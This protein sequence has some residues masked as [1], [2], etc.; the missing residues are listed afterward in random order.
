MFINCIQDDAEGKLHRRTRPDDTGRRDVDVGKRHDHDKSSV[1]LQEDKRRRN[2]DNDDH[3]NRRDAKRRDDDMRDLLHEEKRSHNDDTEDDR[4]RGRTHLQDTSRQDDKRHGDDRRLALHEDKKGHNDDIEDDRGRGRTHLQDTSRHDDKRHGDDRR[5]ALNE[6]KKGHNDDKR[7][8]LYEEKRSGD[9]YQN[10]HRGY[11]AY[12]VVDD[13][14][15]A[16]HE[17]KR[18]RNGGNDDDICRGD[19]TTHIPI[20]NRGIRHFNTNSCYHAVSLGA[21]ASIPE[22][23]NAVLTLPLSPEASICNKVVFAEQRNVLQS[24]KEFFETCLSPDSNIE[25]RTNDAENVLE[26][27]EAV[28]SQMQ[29]FDG[30]SPLLSRFH[31]SDSE[32]PCEWFSHVFNCLGVSGDNL[33]NGS[34]LHNVLAHELTTEITK[35]IICERCKSSTKTVE[36]LPMS[37]LSVSR[38]V[39][40]V[41][42]QSLIDSL[43]STEKNLDNHKCRTCWKLGTEMP[44]KTIKR[45]FTRLPRTFLAMIKRQ[46]FISSNA[47]NH[48]TAANVTK[49]G[50]TMVNIGGLHYEPIVT[51]AHNQFGSDGHFIFAAKELESS[52]WHQFDDLNPNCCRV[53]TRNIVQDL[54]SKHYIIMFRLVDTS[55]LKPITPTI[56][57]HDVVHVDDCS[58]IRDHRDLDVE[59]DLTAEDTS[60]RV[61][62]VDKRHDDDKR[63]AHHEDKISRTSDNEDEDKRSRTSDNEDERDRGRVNYEGKHHE[64]TNGRDVDVGKRHD[65]EKRV[66][67]HE[68]KKSH[69]GHNEDNRD[70]R[71][72][73]QHEDTSMRVAD[74]DKRHDDDK[75]DAHHE[76]KLNRDE[77]DTRNDPDKSID[78]RD[79]KQVRS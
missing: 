50:G 69:N 38:D 72:C 11:A 18:S 49:F 1:A 3:M 21:L 44:T 45:Y 32:D 67:L 24:L 5:L 26:S 40:S 68:C 59:I 61:A 64:D 42:V 78:C 47:A 35:E 19:V 74:V 57:I 46:Q 2:G 37:L 56:V 34:A 65:D 55:Q 36:K 4:G 62:D 63:D 66:S 79:N 48:T 10:D 41:T 12:A 33:T 16:L 51:I 77:D 52:Q 43:A 60:M 39:E 75:R 58:D 71:G 14:S 54:A 70:H 25:D 31:G 27:L 6:D 22:L 8:A 20:Q 9:G 76:H 29:S 13:K 23:V 15:I 53:K 73:I 30:K 17:D 7:L 28:S